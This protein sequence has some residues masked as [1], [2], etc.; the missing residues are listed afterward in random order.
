VTLKSKKLAEEASLD[1]FHSHQYKLCVKNGSALK[2]Y[3]AGLPSVNDV[4]V[5]LDP[6]SDALLHISDT[7]IAGE[8]C[9]AYADDLLDAQR[10]VNG[11]DEHENEDGCVLTTQGKLFWV[12]PIAPGVSR[13]VGGSI[14]HELSVAISELR[15]QGAI[16]R[17]HYDYFTH[18]KCDG[19]GIGDLSHLDLKSQLNILTVENPPFATF[20][21]TANAFYQ[22]YLS[23]KGCK[24]GN[25]SWEKHHGCEAQSTKEGTDMANARWSGYN[26]DQIVEIQKSACKL[27]SPAGTAVGDYFEEYDVVLGDRS[28]PFFKCKHGKT[29][30]YRIQGSAANKV[31]AGDICNWG[32]VGW[33][34]GSYGGGENMVYD[35]DLREKIRLGYNTWHFENERINIPDMYFAGY[36]MTPKRIAKSDMTAAYKDTSLGVVILREPELSTLKKIGRVFEPFSFDLW[37]SLF[38]FCV[39]V[40]ISFWIIE[41]SK[42]NVTGDFTG[43]GDRERGWGRSIK[44][45]KKNYTKTTWLAI[46]T[47]TLSHCHT[48]VTNKGR[49]LSVAFCMFC[50]LVGAAY[51]ASLSA[52]LVGASDYKTVAEASV[53]ELQKAGRLICTEQGTAYSNWLKSNSEI[54]KLVHECTGEDNTGGG[55]LSTLSGPKGAMT[56]ADFAAASREMGLGPKV[57]EMLLKV[58]SGYCGSFI[59]T[60]ELCTYV[61]GKKVLGCKVELAP[62]ILWKQ[63]LG[64]G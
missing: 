1:A 59:D 44:G 3:L 22:E 58:E 64:I 20:N 12:H 40:G 39:F 43:G 8:L 63:N 41:G 2:D 6:S 37:L 11:L 46:S 9:D 36:F 32:F 34:K 27:T 25:P 48:P 38:G 26:P 50:V 35:N 55:T 18:S 53:E 60:K 33:N 51:T 30:E 28:Y 13:T 56:T 14:A 7:L 16:A 52:F 54:A 10:L 5:P 4:L 19:H 61:M 57:Y 42:R 17:M 24:V 49:L 29:F 62:G 31:C 47:I 21:M 23:E 15:E 45:L